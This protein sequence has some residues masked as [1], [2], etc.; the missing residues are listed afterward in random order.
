M[1]LLKRLNAV[2]EN[3]DCNR[4]KKYATTDMAEAI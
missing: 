3:A 1:R 2:E 4:D